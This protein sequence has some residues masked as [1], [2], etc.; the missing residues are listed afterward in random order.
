[1]EQRSKNGSRN[2]ARASKPSAT[3]LPVPTRRR[4][5]RTAGTL[6]LIGGA[7]EPEGEALGAF[8]R[9]SNALDGGKIVGIT[10]ASQDPANSARQWMADFE[11]AG[12][13]HVEIPIV[14]RRDR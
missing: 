4:T 1:M 9:L 12:A 7:C 13:T 11:K 5:D 2:G 6:V 10:T 8:L 14:D 3:P